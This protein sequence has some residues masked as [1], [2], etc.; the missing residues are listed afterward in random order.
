LPLP[1]N[2]AKEPEEKPKKVSKFRA[3]KLAAKTEQLD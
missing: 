2:Q 1:S 3:A